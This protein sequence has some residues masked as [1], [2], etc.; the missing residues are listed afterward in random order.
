M[1]PTLKSLVEQA[2]RLDAERTAGTWSVRVEEMPHYLGGVHI[3]RQIVGGYH[4]QLKDNE[5]VIGT[6]VG[7]PRKEGEPSVSFVW[8]DEADAAFIA[9]SHRW[10]AA[11][12]QLSQ[13]LEEAERDAARYHEIMAL[14]GDLQMEH[15]LCQP[16]A[17]RAC[18]RCNATD[19]LAALLQGY[20]GPRVVASA[21]TPDEAT[22][23]DA[24][25]YR[26][27]RAADQRQTD[28]M[29]KRIWLAGEDLDAAIDAA[30]QKPKE[31][32]RESR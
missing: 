25:R 30:M 8:M 20:R 11:L 24:A 26:Y 18:T 13:L 12:L 6:A 19:D 21:S 4:P 7:V 15:G 28:E 23:K 17:R 3:C 9:E 5:P 22:A 31:T 29:S 2:Q 14:V 27:I 32:S 1:T 10:P 16:R